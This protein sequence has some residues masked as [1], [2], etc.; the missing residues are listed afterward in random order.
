VVNWRDLGH[1]LAGGSEHYAWEFAC[2]LRDA[3][4]S[5]EF[6]T[7]RDT[8][9]ARR[10]VVDRITIVRG[11]GRFGYYRHA[12]VSLL[13]RR[14]RLDLVVDPECGIPSW[15]PAYVGRRT[16]IVL[17]VHHVHQDQFAT[18]FP[19]PLAWLGQVLERVVMPRAYRGV[20]TLAVSP[21]T[22]TEMVERLGWTGPVEILENG[23][24]VPPADRFSPV[25]QDPDRIAVLGRLV[26]HK[27]VDLV[28][29]TLRDLAVDRPG[30]ALDVL[31]KG[32]EEERLRALAVE[33][34]VADRVRFHGFVTEERKWDLL[35][36]ASLH[37]AASD[38]EGWGQV[39]IE[40]AG[41][42]VPTVARDVPGLRDSVRPGETGLL[43]PDDPDLDV[44]GRRL[45]AAVASALDG[46][47]DPVE[48]DRS[49]A[50]CQAWAGR[51][52]W[53]GMRAR[54]AAIAVEELSAS[55]RAR[56]D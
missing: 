11:G 52:S 23:T 17:V 56:R 42:G 40:A 10:E 9:Q 51:F 27:R 49:H 15:S 21:S 13:R 43:V 41:C 31:G 24:A 54:A 28:L 26:P 44:V 6:I 29:R 20:R 33:L 16:A 30:L 46:L 35:R 12:A 19:G 32:P 55:R 53:A 50:A 14:R 2:A 18:Y 47:A 39:V 4:A 45:A 3:G 37:V 25:D 36:H 8:G 7:A 34:G 22:R 5:V 48:R 1:A 38:S